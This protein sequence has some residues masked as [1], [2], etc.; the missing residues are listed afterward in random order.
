[1]STIRI[2][3]QKDW[4]IYGDRESLYVEISLEDFRSFVEQIIEEKIGKT[5]D[6]MDIQLP[7]SW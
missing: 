5:G 2:P 7:Q 1:M 6:D 3:V 4:D